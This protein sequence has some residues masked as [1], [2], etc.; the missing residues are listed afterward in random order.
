MQ[1][2]ADPEKNRGDLGRACRGCRGWWPGGRSRVRPCWPAAGPDDRAAVIAAQ[3]YGLGKVLWIGTDGT[4]AFP[5]PQP[6]TVTI[7]DSG[8]RSVR[9]AAGGALAAGN[10]Q[11]RFGPSSLDTKR[12]TGVKL[13]ARI[14]EGIARGR[15]RALDRGEDLQDRRGQARHCGG[16]A[17]RDRADASGAGA[18]AHVRRP[19]VGS[20]AGLVCDAARRSAARGDAQSRSSVE[21]KVAGGFDRDCQPRE[22]GAC[23]ACRRAR[24]SRTARVCDRRTR[25]CRLRGR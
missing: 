6:A 3:P 9:W 7:T 13:Q 23:G 19:G 2:D 15:A 1:L 4:L 11:V 16:G 12:G 8:G 25:A 18:A 5:V 10:A 14:S 22:L 20:S 21:R 17:R 24:S